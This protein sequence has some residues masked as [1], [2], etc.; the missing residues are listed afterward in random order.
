[1][2]LSSRGRGAVLPWR[3]FTLALL[4]FGLTASPAGQ[5]A[6]AQT[7]R[8]TQRAALSQQQALQKKLNDNALMILGGNPGTSYSAIAHDIA[9]ALGGGDGLRLL[10][11]D[12]PGG[13]DSLRDL[14]LLRGVNLAL[15]PA[16]AEFTVRALLRR[17]HVE[18][19]VV[20][21]APADAVDEVR[22][23]AIAALALTGGKPLR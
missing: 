1:M 4:L 8:A 16:H 18:A 20:K 13:T 23:G 9:S 7:A 22:A 10:A 11:L 12:A 6:F 17:L 14:L 15:W 19:E 5:A 3:S 21:L 2:Q